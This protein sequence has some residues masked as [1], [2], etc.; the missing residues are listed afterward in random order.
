MFH[1]VITRCTFNAERGGLGAA[2]AGNVWV[3]RTS[4]STGADLAWVA[5]Y[6]GGLVAALSGDWEYPTSVLKTWGMA[7]VDAVAP[8]AVDATDVNVSNGTC[9]CNIF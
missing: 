6:V 7:Q 3:L 1:A 9:L 8:V 5:F 2:L 4:F